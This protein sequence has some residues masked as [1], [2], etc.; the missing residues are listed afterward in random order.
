MQIQ[1]HNRIDADNFRPFAES[2]RKGIERLA[3]LWCGSFATSEEPSAIDGVV[4]VG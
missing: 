4:T 2:D 3:A 1:C